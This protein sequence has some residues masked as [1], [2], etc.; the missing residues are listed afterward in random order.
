MTPKALADLHARVFTTPAPWSEAAFASFL[1]DPAC[2]LETAPPNAFALLRRAADE[3]EVLTIA[4][5]PEM[6]RKGLARALLIRALQAQ[7]GASAC[8][9]EV[10]ASNHGAQALY[11]GLGFAEVGRRRHY[12]TTPDR[13]REDALVLRA[14]LPLG[15]AS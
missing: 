14:A 15:I 8:F 7:T 5:A 4:T 9:L 2:H 3:V 6:Q 12:Y 10:A 1:A 11:A 13:Q